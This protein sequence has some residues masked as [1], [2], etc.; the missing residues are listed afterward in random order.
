[1]PPWTPALTSYGAGHD[2][3]RSW[4]EQAGENSFSLLR[5]SGQ[6]TPRRRSRCGNTPP[7]ARLP[8]EGV[9]EQLEYWTPTDPVGR[10]GNPGRERSRVGE[11]PEAES[12]VE[13]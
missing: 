10:V 7:A 6:T 5:S 11:T 12:G 8:L 9:V 4:P 13:Y 2:R 1:M 3:Q